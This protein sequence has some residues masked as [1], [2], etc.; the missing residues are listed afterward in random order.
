MEGE[1]FHISLVD[2]A[3]PFCVNTP[4]SIPFAYR[5]KLRAELDLLQTQGIVALVTEPTEWCAPIV[6]TPKKDSDR[7]RLCV[8]LSRLNR[9]VR[10][11]RY[12]SSSPA[13]AVADIAA[14]KAKVFTTL[15]A[16]KGYHQ[17]PTGRREPKF[18][19]IYYTIWAIQIP[20]SPIR[21]II[22]LR[23]LQPSNG[24]S[25]FRIIWVPSRS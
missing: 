9:Y 14:D 22:E 4:R 8:D 12:Q 15:D 6:I 1:E 23:A 7:I 11:Q 21:N 24:R 13:Q 25:F 2:D 19:H 5:E 3:K 10:R 17:M 20:S 16:M 18:D